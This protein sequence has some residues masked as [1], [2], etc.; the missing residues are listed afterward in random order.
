M[1]AEIEQLGSLEFDLYSLTRK[2]SAEIDRKQKL[3][4]NKLY[5]LEEQEKILLN[6]QKIIEVLFKF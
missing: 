1:K 5:D 2:E 3:K 4:R 6:Y